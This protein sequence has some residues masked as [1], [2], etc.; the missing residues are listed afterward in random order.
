MATCRVRLSEPLKIRS[1]E[2]PLLGDDRSHQVRRGDIESR[3]EGL[4]AVRRDRLT[5]QVG[6][7]LRGALLNDN[8]A[9]AR[10][11]Q[12]QGRLGR[13]HDEGNAV[14]SGGQRQRVCADLF[15]TSPFA[16]IR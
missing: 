5:V 8:P 10:K 6:D 1:L 7:L 4:C 3:V 14:P 13:Y 11:R 16:A 15:A 9:T 12:V 2:D